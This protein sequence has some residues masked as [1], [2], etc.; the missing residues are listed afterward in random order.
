MERGRPLGE[1]GR[2][3]ERVKGVRAILWVVVV[4]NLAILV[5]TLHVRATRT[6]YEIARRQAEIRALDYE[7][8]QLLL[9]KAEAQRP[10]NLHRRAQ[11]LG[12]EIQRS[13]LERP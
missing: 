13:P 6:R 5:V 7:H 2:T 1:R 8:R 11:A 10:E 3:G 4:A 12:L 9:K